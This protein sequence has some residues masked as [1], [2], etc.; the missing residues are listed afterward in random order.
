MRKKLIVV[1]IVRGSMMRNIGQDASVRSSALF[2]LCASCV[3]DQSHASV[4]LPA[5]NAVDSTKP[6]INGMSIIMLGSKKKFTKL[7]NDMTT[8]W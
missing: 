5:P 8:I 1:P 3:M 2:A 6:M 4:R 7:R